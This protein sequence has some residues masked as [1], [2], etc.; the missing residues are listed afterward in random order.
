MQAFASSSGFLIS[1]KAKLWNGTHND[2]LLVLSDDALS[3]CLADDPENATHRWPLSDVVSAVR[4]GRTVAFGLKTG[5]PWARS[6]RFVLDDIDRAEELCRHCARHCGGSIE[7]A[8]SLVA[9]ARRAARRA[10]VAEEAYLAADM[11]GQCMADERRRLA[12]EVTR[13]RA[14]SA[15]TRARLAATEAEADELRQQAEQATAVGE[16]LAEALARHAL[17]RG[18]AAEEV[19]AQEETHRT[20]QVHRRA[21]EQVL[22][23]RTAEAE[24]AEARAEAAKTAAEVTVAA[25][26]A[27]EARAEKART[28]AEARTEAAEAAEARAEKART[29][30]EARTEAAEAAEARA[31]AARAAAEVMAAAVEAAEA[32]AEKARTAAEA[33]TEAAEAKVAAEQEAEARAAEVE[34]EAGSAVADARTTRAEASGADKS[35]SAELDRL[36]AEIAELTSE[37]EGERSAREVVVARLV[38]VSHSHAD[39]TLQWEMREH[40]ATNAAIRIIRRASAMA[41]VRQCFAVLRG[42][43]EEERRQRTPPHSQMAASVGES[44][45]SLTGQLEA[46]AAL[47]KPAAARLA[48]EQIFRPVMALRFEDE[49]KADATVESGSESLSEQGL[50]KLPPE[51][52]GVE[53]SAA[54]VW[55]ADRTAEAL[56]VVALL[57][58]QLE[59]LALMHAQLLGPLADD[60]DAIS[61]TTSIDGDGTDDAEEGDEPHLVTPHRYSIAGEAEGVYEGYEGYEGYQPGSLAGL[62]ASWA[63][64]QSTPSSTTT[65]QAAESSPEATHELRTPTRFA[66]PVGTPEEAEAGDEDEHE[67]GGYGDG[68]Q[69]VEEGEGE[70]DEDEDGLSAKEAVLMALRQRLFEKVTMARA[71]QQRL[72]RTLLCKDGQEGCRPTSPDSALALLRERQYSTAGIAFGAYEGFEPDR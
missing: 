31:G 68:G 19:E 28:A 62:T 41:V 16:E 33:R 21:V 63:L 1:G 2:R 29:A 53:I 4:S 7:E 3:L 38:E 26:E 60:I 48:N 37:L 30:A 59:E 56:A 11:A 58:S 25:A 70:E 8:A 72:E 9:E 69:E 32:R 61:E 44:L 34:A 40:H 15:A 20:E 65:Q 71:L 36:H 50:G 46:A 23:A 42:N 10:E 54:E 57:A 5:L 66:V 12:D 17:R 55:S 47:S 51:S 27:A 39:N 35:L 49:P 22:E 45:P 67:H 43:V 14:D 24:A 18:E 13:V 52:A 6:P 64:W